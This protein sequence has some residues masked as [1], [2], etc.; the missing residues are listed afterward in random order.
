MLPANRLHEVVRYYVGPRGDAA[1]PLVSPVFGEWHNPPPALIMASRS[2]I[3]V[4]DA[5]GLAEALRQ[6][7][8][9]VRLELWRGQPHAWPTFVGLLPEADRAVDQAG[10][11]IATEI[12]RGSLGA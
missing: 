6:G 10:A 5:I 4:D 11:F 8:G 12:R 2:E 7:G 1:D 9:D 3:L